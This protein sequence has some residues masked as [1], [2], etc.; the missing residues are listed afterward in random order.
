VAAPEAAGAVAGAQDA[1]GAEVS[2]RAPH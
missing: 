2:I 1:A